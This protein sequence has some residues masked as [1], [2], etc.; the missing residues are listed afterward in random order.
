[1]IEYH[2]RVCGFNNYPDI[3]WEDNIPFYIIC[4]CCGCES[5]N[6]DYTVDSTKQ[7]RKKWL[8]KGANWFDFKKKPQHWDM[9]GQFNKI[10]QKF[11]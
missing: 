5:G 1:M 2:C 10:P 7:Y 6:E 8:D 11:V 3:F 9:I 4:S